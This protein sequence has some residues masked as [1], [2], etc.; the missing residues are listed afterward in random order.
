MKNGK[1]QNPR[2]KKKLTKVKKSLPFSFLDT[3][4]L[5]VF[6]TFQEKWWKASEINVITCELITAIIKKYG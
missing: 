6:S 2:F 3:I 1:S 4:S 5:L